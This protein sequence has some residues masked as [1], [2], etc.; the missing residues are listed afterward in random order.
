MVY[1]IRNDSSNLIVYDPRLDGAIVTDPELKF[2]DNQCGSLRFTMY[3]DH[4]DYTNIHKRRT[5][6]AVYRGDALNP[7]F[8]G[9]CT[10]GTDDQTQIVDFYFED[11]MSV[12]RDSM[13]NAFEYHGELIPFF[14]GL[15]ATH[16]AQV[17]TWQQIQPGYVT[18]TDP[19]DYIYRLSEKELSTWEV[20]QTRLVNVLGGHLRMRYV[21]GVA[22]LD[23]L[24]GSTTDLDPYL[25]ASTQPIEIGENLKDF[26]R[27]ISASETYSACIP[28][29]A[30]ATFYDDDGVEYKKRIGIESTNSGSKYLINDTAVSQYGYRCAPIEM[31]TWDD[32]TDPI[33]LKAK[34]L[35]FLNGTLV[36]LSNS[37][38]L[39]AEDLAHL[40]VESDTFGF[41]DYVRVYIYTANIDQIYLLTGI[42]IPLDDPSE[43]TI[44]LGVTTLSLT[45]QQA[46]KNSDLV[47]K[48]DAVESSVTEV[49]HQISTDIEQ[50]SETFN[51]LIESTAESIMS[52]CEAIYVNTTSF[53]EYQQ[54]VS[55][56][57]TQTAQ[58]FTMQFNA[59]TQQVTNLDNTVTTQITNTSKYIRFVDGKIQIG[60]EG[61]PLSLEIRNDRIVFI[62]DNVEVAY[63]T[64]GRLYVK[65]VEALVSL[66]IG[67]FAFMPTQAGGM[68]LKYI[69]T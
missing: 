13:Q 33:N 21:S 62:V 37:V 64:A 69:G 29:G 60:V 38:K 26:A 9:I 4:P 68:S 59:L 61:K 47:S 17:Q 20:I 46:R 12:L 25:N 53:S 7:I 8:K 67:N 52:Q 58:G 36:K 22:Y 34:G 56:M 31:T 35:A 54:Q 66:I 27:L 51:R 43:L 18:V 63:F 24:E 41:L 19:N 28:K 50:V 3:P 48:V 2:S 15:L 39:T 57:L 5:I 42:T 32:V 16:N 30:E 55:S 49:Q 14:Q 45:D 44:S 11:F 6:Y 23:Y 10:E 65:E 40:G 1:Q